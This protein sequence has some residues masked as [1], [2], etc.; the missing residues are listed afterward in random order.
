MKFIVT[1]VS[2][3][4]KSSKTNKEYLTL[5]AVDVTSGEVSPI[6]FEK[7]QYEAYNLDETKIV[8]NEDLQELV[9]NAPTVDIQFNQRGRVT[10]IN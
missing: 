5:H 4:F 10:S 8:S 1:S 7:E 3:P 9:S 6:L 2:K